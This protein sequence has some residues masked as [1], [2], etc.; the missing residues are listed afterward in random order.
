MLHTEGDAMGN[1]I[2]NPMGNTMPDDRCA[3]LLDEA[4][5]AGLRITGLPT[6][7]ERSS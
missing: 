6:K 2:G 1:N 5:T 7:D 3:R 4:A